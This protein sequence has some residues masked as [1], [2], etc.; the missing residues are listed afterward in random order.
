[1]Q[2]IEVLISHYYQTEEFTNRI[3]IRGNVDYGRVITLF[4]ALIEAKVHF[5]IRMLQKEEQ[6]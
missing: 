3:V 5:E 4:A 2:D 1:M 6:I